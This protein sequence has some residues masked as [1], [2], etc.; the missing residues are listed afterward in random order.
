MDSQKVTKEC[1]V[2]RSLLD[3]NSNITK[4]QRHTPDEAEPRCVVNMDCKAQFGHK[5]TK[6]Y[7]GCLAASAFLLVIICGAIYYYAD[8]DCVEGII[9][10]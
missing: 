7:T 1:E 9:L 4:D 2:K 10:C 6:I 3:S 8:K 5:T